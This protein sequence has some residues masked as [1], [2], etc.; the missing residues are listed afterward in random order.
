MKPCL[1]NGGAEPWYRLDNRPKPWFSNLS[2][3]PP[4][5]SGCHR[6]KGV[7]TRH[8]GTEIH[9]RECCLSFEI[10]N[11]PQL[12]TLN[13]DVKW[14]CIH[15][16]LWKHFQ[17]LEFCAKRVKETYFCTN[18]PRQ[19]NGSSLKITILLSGGKNR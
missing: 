5:H 1:Q 15:Y 9:S 16:L 14:I 18:Y 2:A 6:N 7:K 11:F 10:S 8:P 4:C 3:S 13:L 17:V 19:D 12:K